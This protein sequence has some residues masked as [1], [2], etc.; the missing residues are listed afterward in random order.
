MKASRR[1]SSRGNTPTPGSPSI[2]LQG[3][4]DSEIIDT[5]HVR[6]PPMIP[7]SAGLCATRNQ[8]RAPRRDNLANLHAR[9]VQL[10]PL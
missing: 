2:Y 9:G 6:R 3:I 1:S 10:D 7:A 5:V 8:Y 4:D